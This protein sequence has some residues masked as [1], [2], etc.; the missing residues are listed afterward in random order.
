M[1]DMTSGGYIPRFA[2]VLL[3]CMNPACF[4]QT[5][6]IRIVD[7]TNKSPVRNEH[8]YVAGMSGNAATEKEERLEL[9]T[10]PIRADLSL[11]TDTNGEAGF[12]LPKPAP[13][14]FY[15]RAALSGSH[16]D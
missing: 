9:I 5:V 8:V 16:W 12:D 3:S 7:L 6:T 4:G 2:L 13:A 14:Y 11:T 15:I 1:Q 10:K